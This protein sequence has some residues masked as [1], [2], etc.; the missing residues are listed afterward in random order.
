MGETIPTAQFANVRPEVEVVVSLGEGEDPRAAFSYAKQLANAAFDEVKN[1]MLGVKP[2][3][4]PH[5]A[6]PV[7]Q[8]VQVGAPLAPPVPPGNPLNHANSN[9]GGV[10]PAVAPPPPGNEIPKVD[11]VTW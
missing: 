5:Q 9:L 3:V 11:P 4:N 10:R 6:L 7:Q 2:K 1:E 8:P